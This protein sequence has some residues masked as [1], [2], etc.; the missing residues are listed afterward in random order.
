MHLV[1]NQFS[2]S[3]GTAVIARRNEKQRL[4]KANKVYYGRCASGIFTTVFWQMELI[5]ANS[6]RDSGTK[7]TRHV[8]N[9][10]YHVPLNCKPTGFAHVNGKKPTV[11]TLK[12]H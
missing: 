7:F 1:L 11:G 4:C 2:W 6:K 10:A 8:Q 3:L 9:F 12:S 5:C